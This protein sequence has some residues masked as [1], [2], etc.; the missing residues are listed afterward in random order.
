MKV[1]VTG[2]SGN[3]GTALL[4]LLCS[5]PGCD[6]TGLARRVP[7]GTPYSRARWVPCDIGAPGSSA[8]LEQAFAGADAVVHLAWAVHPATGDPPM[9]RTNLTGSRQVLRAAV[10]A[11]VPHVVCAS[12]VAAYSPGPRWSAVSEDWPRDGVPS[13]AYSRG[14]ADLERMLDTFAAGH[15]D[16]RIARVRPCAVLQ[17]DAAGQFG[18]WLLSPLLPEVA[19]GRGWLPVPLWPGLRVQF[20]HSADVGEAIVRILERGASGAFN[21]AAGPPLT[22]E[23]LSDVLGGARLPIPRRPLE[24]LTWFSWRSGMQPL[25]P[26]WLRLA[27]QAAI[28][29]TAR[30]ADELGWRPRFEPHAVLEDLLDGLRAGA[31]TG[32]VPLAP[33]AKGLGARLRALAPARPT[34]QS[35][36]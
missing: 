8:V 36:S 23:K 7:V 20:V 29:D 12:S 4:R 22:A 13:S 28:V 18:R 6:V 3:I 24:G 19:V 9:D 1:V 21:L 34:H 35:Q 10:A 32:S 5:D 25:H 26:G 27:D 16:L 33:P 2:A 14:K 30:A 17:R 31:G 11:G 15:P